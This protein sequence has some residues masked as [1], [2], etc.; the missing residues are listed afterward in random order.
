MQTTKEIIADIKKEM[1]LQDI[2]ITELALKID[3][4]SQ[5]L[6]KILKNEN[7]QL[8]SLIKICNGLNLKIVLTKDGI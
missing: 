1:I 6:S 5:N 3:M 4:S 2:N 7:P 8:E